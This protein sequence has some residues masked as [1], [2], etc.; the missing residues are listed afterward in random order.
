[1]S[2]GRILSG[3]K[4]TGNLHLGNYLGAIRNWVAM[5]KD[6]ECFFCV[7]DLHAITADR[8]EPAELT[9]T[10]REVA[11]GYI[12][13]GI[14]PAR[15]TLFVQSH[16]P[17]H[18]EL[19]WIFNCVARLGWLNRM[20]QFKDKAGKNR[21]TASAGLYVYPNLM[22][23]DILIYK[24]THVPVGEDQKQHIELARDIAQKF[25][26]DYGVDLFVLPEP[27]IQGAATRVM[28]LRD[29]AKKMSKSD[30]GSD[31][32]VIYMT[33]SADDIAAKLRK[34]TTDPHPLPESVAGLEGRAEA[35]NLLNIYAALTDRTLAE[36]V[37]EAAGWGFGQFKTRLTETAVGVLGPINAE[38]AR[39]MADP[40]EL[41]AILAKGA[42]KARE[43]AAPLLAEVYRTVG[44]LP[45]R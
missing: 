12:A 36:V 20:T 34:A 2:R 26:H 40:A 38:M 35:A 16:V 37:A 18:A 10:T 15:A 45:A 44:F 43:T 13:S 28:S 5:Q 22:A 4:P 6:Y 42:A 29:G 27:V 17:A 25:N 24:A 19:A 11:A 9:R 21:D 1:M 33:D 31:Y 32:A 3:I 14:D 23:A 8:I 30:G 41:D 39:L 7:V